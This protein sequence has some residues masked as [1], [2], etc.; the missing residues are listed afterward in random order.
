[1]Q[2][3]CRSLLAPGGVRPELVDLTRS[4]RGSHCLDPTGAVRD[5]VHC[6][7]GSGGYPGVE[8][9]P[10][11]LTGFEVSACGERAGVCGVTCSL[12]SCPALAQARILIA[13]LAA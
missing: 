3:A 12:R 4:L 8:R 2:R 5:L 6:R 1:M 11:L 9:D 13:V 10:L 7:L